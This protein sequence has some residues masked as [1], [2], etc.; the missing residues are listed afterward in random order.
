MTAQWI[1]W[2]ILFRSNRLR[3]PYSTHIAYIKT[4][5]IQC[6]KTTNEAKRKEHERTYHKSS[7]PS[8]YTIANVI[9]KSIC[10]VRHVFPPKRIS[11]FWSPSLCQVSQIFIFL[12]FRWV[13]FAF[14]VC[15]RM[16]IHLPL[17]KMSFPENFV[18]SKPERSS[19]ER[20]LD[21]T[22][23]S[24]RCVQFTQLFSHHFQWQTRI[25][26]WS[27]LFWTSILALLPVPSSTN[28]CT[29]Q[30]S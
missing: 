14:F 29:K 1:G 18:A 5:V 7:R 15:L 21:A 6:Q 16:R 26:F 25:P 3:S 20:R 24:S 8:S 22:V 13:W 27:N 2:Y 4:T 28:E 19:V 10:F 11:L 23:L 17:F 12:R 30:F 9:Y